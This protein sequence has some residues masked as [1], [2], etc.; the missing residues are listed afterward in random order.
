MAG[1]RF[2]PVAFSLFC[3]FLGA[4]P[5]GLSAQ[6]LVAVPSTMTHKLGAYYISALGKDLTFYQLLNGRHQRGTNAYNLVNGIG[7]SADP[8]RAAK[9]TSPVRGYYKSWSIGGRVIVDVFYKLVRCPGGDPSNCLAF[10]RI[11]PVN[12]PRLSGAPV[13]PTVLKQSFGVR[14]LWLLNANQAAANTV[15]KQPASE[16]KLYVDD[17]FDSGR[18]YYKVAPPPPPCRSAYPQ[19]YLYSIG[20]FFDRPQFNCVLFG[21]VYIMMTTTDEAGYTAMQQYGTSP[22][23]CDG[24]LALLF[25]LIAPQRGF[26]SS[27]PQIVYLARRPGSVPFTLQLAFPYT[28]DCEQLP[29]NVSLLLQA[30]TIL[31]QEGNGVDVTKSRVG[32]NLAIPEPITSLGFANACT[33]VYVAYYGAAVWG[34]T[35]GIPETS[36]D[37]TFL[38][39]LIRTN[40]GDT[41]IAAPSVNGGFSGRD[42]FEDACAQL[43]FGNA[44]QQ[45]EGVVTMLQL[46]PTAV[47]DQVAFNAAVSRCVGKGVY[48]LPIQGILPQI[49]IDFDATKASLL[50]STEVKVHLDSVAANAASV[51][52]LEIA[53]ASCGAFVTRTIARS[54]YYRTRRLSNFTARLLACLATLVAVT[55]LNVPNFALIDRS[56]SNHRA[57]RVFAAASSAQYKPSN[58]SAVLLSETHAFVTVEGSSATA[59]IGVALYVLAACYA[60]WDTWALFG[61]VIRGSAD[62]RRCLGNAT[63]E[64]GR[65]ITVE[66]RETDGRLHDLLNPAAV[67]KAGEMADYELRSARLRATICGRR[68]G[69]P[70]GRRFRAPEPKHLLAVWISRAAR[71]FHKYQCKV[72]RSRILDC[73]VKLPLMQRGR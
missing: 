37:S 39:T 67:L 24:S 17:V 35:N 1:R 40:A 56:L 46:G 30:A 43:Y 38:E 66:W 50:A 47:P 6:G 70:P 36:S 31:A 14:G 26:P 64:D 23:N 61:D 44:T 41:C 34:Q 32:K 65:R 49:A 53:L 52:A 60:V 15:L 2:F 11:I 19:T 29:R 4:L 62:A 3:F 71:R 63:V 54:S 72:G 59:V 21:G 9:E 12:A 22:E 10:E 45:R 18:I 51:V 20:E 27:G 58:C 55:V 25:N 57:R 5:S 73:G 69:T 33:P 7:D 42:Y 13:I 68:S 8:I 48:T 28:L 16:E